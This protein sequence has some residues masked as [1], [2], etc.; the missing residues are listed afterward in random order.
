MMEEKLNKL[1]FA[2]STALYELNL[3]YEAEITEGYVSIQFTYKGRSYGISAILD[4]EF[5]EDSSEVDLIV[6]SEVSAVLHAAAK[7]ADGVITQLVE[8]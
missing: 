5:L 7:N 3:E 2:L 4:N 1:L 8:L 6:I